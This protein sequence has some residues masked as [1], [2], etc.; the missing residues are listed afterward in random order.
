MEGKLAVETEVGRWWRREVEGR[1]LLA[2][3]IERAALG[4][5]RRGW[6]MGLA[7]L[8]HIERKCLS[9]R[10]ASAKTT[11]DLTRE[12]FANSRTRVSI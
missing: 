3:E 7:R 10:D 2:V 6:H 4:W 11:M 5:R 9:D 1:V 8:R 12:G